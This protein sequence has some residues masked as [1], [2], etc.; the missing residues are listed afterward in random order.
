MYRRFRV[1]PGTILAFGAVLAS[2]LAC[3]WPLVEHP[4]RMLVGNQH[5]EMNDLT[6]WFLPHRMVPQLV[7]FRHGQLPF[8][9]PWWGGGS[10]FLGNLQSA[11]FYPLNWPFWFCDV[12]RTI[13]W[14]LV[15]HHLIAAVGAYALCRKLGGGTVGAV[16]AAVAFGGSPVLLARSSEGHL[17]AICIVSWYPWALL[18]YEGFRAGDRRSTLG[19]VLALGLAILAGHLQEAFYL[20]LS[21]TFVCLV[22]VLWSLLVRDWGRAARLL[23]GWVLVGVATAGLVAAELIPMVIFLRHTATVAR[24]S[25]DGLGSPGL[26]NLLQMLHP[27][28]LGGTTNYQGP[29]I[30][31]WE[32]ICSFGL[33]ALALAVLGV[34]ASIYDQ[35]PVARLFAV[36]A[37][38][39]L[40][41]FAPR[42]PVLDAVVTHFPGLKLLRCPGRWLSL[43]ALAVSILAGI[44]LDAVAASRY[45]TGIARR[46]VA[47]WAGTLL[48]IVV[49]LV[50]IL[51]ASGLSSGDRRTSKQEVLVRLDSHSLASHAVPWFALAGTI[52]FVALAVAFPKNGLLLAIVIVPLGVLESSAFAHA[53][54]KSQ[55][56]GWLPRANPLLDFVAERSSG[57]RI[58]CEQSVVLDL[59]AQ[60][61]E[62]LKVQDYE[63]AALDQ[64]LQALGVALN[65]RF[66]LSDLHGF[67]DLDMG[68]ASDR[69]LDLWSARFLVLRSTDQRP[70]RTTGWKLIKTVQLPLSAV[71]AGSDPTEYRFMVW[72]NQDALP[73]GFVVGRAHVLREGE[74]ERDALSQLD[75][76]TEVLLDR[77]DLPTG[78]R[79]TYTAATRVEDTPNR[80]AFEV[81][82]SAPGYL[83]LADTWYPGWKATVDGRTVPVLRAN[84]AFRAVALPQAG[85]HHVV[86]SYYPVGLN[87]GLALSLT[88]M[89]LLSL[90]S[91]RGRRKGHGDEP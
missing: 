27:F 66:P 26:A 87:S 11:V 46:S 76:R 63:P 60:E 22:E 15:L 34:V 24:L 3:F 52:A 82:T 18:M 9:C 70:V 12:A 59:E 16:F 2:V 29:G 88:T 14:A 68:N 73:R 40:L 32:A 51:G 89:V 77:D 85:K 33:V 23:C 10:P 6:F 30:Y 61:R 8:W 65:S 43:S 53:T 39:F 21:L 64:P 13:S 50:A 44:G 75:P 86:F 48:V 58:V 17:A 83:V 62:L 54:L 19:L 81:E 79:Q 55:S 91:M 78:P 36:G 74:T 72:E 31:Y 38:A 80:V 25:N 37:C 71:P 20:V 5:G 57:W 56:P 35:K 45:G 28:A 4:G 84:I 67:R 41:A 90:V 42:L 7:L 1:S 69:L 49:A 47:R